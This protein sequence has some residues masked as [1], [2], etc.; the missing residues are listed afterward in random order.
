MDRELPSTRTVG[1]K[2]PT[3]C[4]STNRR[5]WVF[6]T[7]KKAIPTRQWFR[8]MPTSFCKPFSKLTLSTNRV[9]CLS[10]VKAMVDIMLQRLLIAFGEETRLFSPIPSRSTCLVSALEMVSP[11]QKN[12][13]VRRFGLV[14]PPRYISSLLLFALLHHCSRLR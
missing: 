8:K 14:L 13:T 4:G 9:P 2:A 1:P 10:L 11:I 3:C 7:D 12:N 5:V 6:R